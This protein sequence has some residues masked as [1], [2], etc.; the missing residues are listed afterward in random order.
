MKCKLISLLVISLFVI[1]GTQAQKKKQSKKIVLKGL[2]LD[3]DNNAVSKAFIFIDDNLNKTLSNSKGKFKAK[4]D[5][6][7]KWITIISQTSGIVEMEYLGEEEM[8]FVLSKSLP[9]K[10]IPLSAQSALQ[11][12]ISCSV[13]E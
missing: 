3:A 2:V 12:S 6:N 8:S 1:N 7:T 5:P 4:L 10:S 9:L 13:T 11:P